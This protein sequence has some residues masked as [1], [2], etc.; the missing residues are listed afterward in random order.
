MSTPRSFGDVW[1]S[2]AERLAP[3][4]GPREAEGIV[5]AVREDVFQEKSDADVPTAEEHALL[6]EIMNRLLAGEPVQY[7]TGWAPFYGYMLEVTPDVLIPRP[8]T[9]EL[10]YEVLHHPAF[11]KK[12]GVRVLDVGTGSG[13]IAVALARERPDWTVHAIDLSEKA[14]DVARRNAG[15]LGVDVAFRQMDVRDEAGWTALPEF[16][17]IV[18]NPPYIAPSERDQLDAHVLE[19]EPATALFV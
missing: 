16:D 18:S 13:C 9:E 15:R 5:R 10:V 2:M 3:V 6:D 19:H 11:A 4:V 17:L 12:R 1:A 14:L 8:E 7:V